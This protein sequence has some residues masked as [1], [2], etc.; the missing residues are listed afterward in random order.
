M[1]LGGD[2]FTSPHSLYIVHAVLDSDASGGSNSITVRFDP[3]YTSLV[4][5][6]QTQVTSGAAAIGCRMEIRT[7]ALENVTLQ[8]EMPLVAVSGQLRTQGVLWTPPALMVTAETAPATSPPFYT[9][10]ID[11]VDTEALL[12]T[13][14]IYNF[15]RR[16]RELA[17][18]NLLLSSLTRSVGAV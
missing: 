10:A 7:S 2:G 11:N 18:L 16:A 13:A 17:P 5:Y 1:P 4:S 15:D 9:S 3:R 14:R 12:L 6:L 8:Q